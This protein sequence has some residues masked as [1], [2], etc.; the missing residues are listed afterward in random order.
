MKQVAG[1]DVGKQVLDVSI[2]DTPMQRYDNTVTGCQQLSLFLSQ[3]AVEVV[4]CEATGGYE[5]GLIEA[6]EGIGVNVH[7]A[8]PNK[9]RAYARALGYLAK[10]DRLDA[11]VLRSYGEQVRLPFDRKRPRRA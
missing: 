1:I 11:Q 6:L 4:V 8:H 3:N 5:R 10:T 2:Q 7:V 9:V